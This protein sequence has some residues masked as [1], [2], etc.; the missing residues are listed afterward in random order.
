VANDSG[1]GGGGGGGGGHTIM[2]NFFN[3]ND[4]LSVFA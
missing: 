3:E 2:T 1:L 4:Q